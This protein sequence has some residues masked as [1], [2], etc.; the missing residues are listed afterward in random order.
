M[1][2]TLFD[3]AIHL[4]KIQDLG[5]ITVV[6]E[7]LEHTIYGIRGWTLSKNSA[8]YMSQKA[9]E[10][11]RLLLHTFVILYGYDQPRN[12]RRA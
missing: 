11:M 12:G 1:Q 6:A 7:R 10:W 9:S 8:F 2:S 3:S 5:W 4:I